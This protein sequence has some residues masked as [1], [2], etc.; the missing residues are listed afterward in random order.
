MPEC[1][2]M[3]N[4]A[5]AALL[6]ALTGTGPLPSEVPA[7]LV[8]LPEPAGIGRLTLP[9]AG[10]TAPLVVLL[11]DTVGEDGRAEPMPRAWPRAASRR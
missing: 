1:S 11:P 7:E 4:A 5:T 6:V 3:P 8:R 9:H 2:A 10:G